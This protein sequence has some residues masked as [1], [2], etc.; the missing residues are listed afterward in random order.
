MTTED[1]SKPARKKGCGTVAQPIVRTKTKKPSHSHF[2]RPRNNFT[3]SDSDNMNQFEAIKTGWQNAKDSIDQ[4]RT[5]V[6]QVVN[7]MDQV[8]AQMDQFE[9]QV[10]QILPQ[11]IPAQDQQ[12]NDQ[13]D[14]V[15]VEIDDNNNQIEAGDPDNN[16]D[17][18]HKQQTQQRQP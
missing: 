16:N 14:L 17:G 8:K 11:Q 9:Q 4:V 3:S 13:Q 2:S 1:D 12:I 6:D 5:Q 18:N 10:A 15:G 7:D